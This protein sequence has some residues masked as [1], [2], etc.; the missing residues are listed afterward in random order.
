MVDYILAVSGFGRC[1]SSMVMQML[2]LG[3][4]RFDLQKA[5]WSYCEDGRQ[6]KDSDKSWAGEYVGSALKWLEPVVYVPSN[7][8]S[9]RT[10]W[11]DRDRK[12][13]AKSTVKFNR[14]R[15]RPD[16]CEQMNGQSYKQF[17]RGRN[18]RRSD[19]LAIWERRGPVLVMRYERIKLDPLSAA[20]RIAEFSGH[21][22]DVNAMAEA[23]VDGG[24]DCKP[25]L[26]IEKRLTKR[27][28]PAQS[29]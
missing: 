8:F 17:L 3:G 20:I 15:G 6:T 16:V 9:W 13:Q 18:Q 28:P 19:A 29:H 4:M 5:P 26:S 12:T 21:D 23:V 24:I 2:Y 11:L 10:I 1:G 27:G 14:E 22:L 25:D 7:E